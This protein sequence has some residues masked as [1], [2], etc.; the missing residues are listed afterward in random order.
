MR[1]L[2]PPFSTHCTITMCT[3]GPSSSI[4]LLQEEEWQEVMSC[5]G[6]SFVVAM[7]GG[8]PWS[9]PW[10]LPW[11]HGRCGIAGVELCSEGQPTQTLPQS[12]VVLSTAT[13]GP[14]EGSSSLV[15]PHPTPGGRCP[16]C[17]RQPGSVAPS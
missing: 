16:G 15:M 13:P 17:G 6:S 5:L 12:C 14:S 4:P 8:V 7:Q 3:L 11:S 10:S 2:K 9:H 1:K